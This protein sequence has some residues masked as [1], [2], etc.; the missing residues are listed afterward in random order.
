MVTLHN[1]VVYLVYVSPADSL[2]ASPKL[3]AAFASREG[4]E[5]YVRPKLGDYMVRVQ[6]REVK[7]EK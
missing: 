6:I 4:A 1:D 7:V 2:G 3:V 5:E